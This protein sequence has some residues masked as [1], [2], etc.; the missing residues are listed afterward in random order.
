MKISVI[1]PALNEEKSIGS[2]IKDIPLDLVQEVIVIDN[3]SSDNT[4]EVA[5]KHGAT[6]LSEPRRGYGSACMKGVNYINETDIVI[7]LDGDYSDHPEEIRELVRPILDGQADLV[8]GSRVLGKSEKGSMHIEQIFGNWLATL[9]IRVL[10]GYRYTDLGPFRAIKYDKLIKLDMENKPLGWTI[11]MQI[12]ALLNKLCVKEIP[13]SY[14]KRI[15]KSKL[16]GTVLGAISSSWSIL[17]TIF[18]YGIWKR[19]VISNQPSTKI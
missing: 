4:A 1:I 9:L 7:F 18:K 6:L 13:V 12:K 2:V 8:I 10:F 19:L 3:G 5:R 17:Y 15:G 14:R 16:S 11:E